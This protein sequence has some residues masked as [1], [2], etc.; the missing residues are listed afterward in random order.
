MNRTQLQLPNSPDLPDPNK[1]RNKADLSETVR[2]IAVATKQLYREKT[3][4]DFRLKTLED[5]T[6]KHW[7]SFLEFYNN[8]KSTVLP[9][10]MKQDGVGDV[11][12]CM[13]TDQSFGIGID[14]SQN[15]LKISPECPLS[16]IYYFAMNSTGQ[17]RV[18][19]G[20]YID[21]FSDD[22]TFAD[23]SAT[24]LVTE[25][26]IGAY[27]ASVT[28]W[29][30]NAINGYLYPRTLTDNVG[31]N[32]NTPASLLELYH[33]TTD[34]ILTITAGHN[35]D[36]DPQIQFRTDAVPTAKWGIR[37]DGTNDNLYIDYLAGGGY[38][39]INTS[40]AKALEIGNGAAGVD[41]YIEVNGETNNLI[42]RAMEDEDYWQFDDDIMMLNQERIYFDSTDTYIGANAD[43]PEDLE[44]AAD[45]DILL[46]PDGDVRVSTDLSVN[47]TI[48]SGRDAVDNQQLMDFP[49]GLELRYREG[50]GPLYGFNIFNTGFDNS[51]FFN[52]IEGTY[53]QCLYFGDGDPGFNIFGISSKEDIDP[54]WTPRFVINQDGNVGIGTNTP[55]SLFEMRLNDA[56]P[57]LTIT[58]GHNTDYDPQIQFRTDAVPTSK[59]GIRVDGTNDNLY[60]DYLAGGGYPI[61]NTSLAKALEI[62]NGA[63][64]VDYYEEWNGETNNG[65]RRWMEDEDYWQFDD[66]IL[67][68]N[69]ERIYFDTTDTYIGANVD[70][71]EDLVIA[72]NQDI[73]LEPDNATITNSGR[74]NNTTRVVTTPYNI[75]ATDEIIVVDTDAVARTTNLPAGVDGTHYSISN[76]GTSGNQV[77]ISPNGAELLLG[78][79]AN[80]LLSDGESLDL[81]YETTEGWVAT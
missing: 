58:A 72:A 64:G 27:V 65:I 1:V 41:Y 49:G 15:V 60:I 50:V 38:P 45:Q 20:V 7:L 62:G 44:I 12:I 10:R 18:G 31:I 34:P 30:R 48:I 8:D 9:I 21:D 66:D 16:D 78:V 46:Q 3:G 32:T 68:Q 23:L 25:R 17:I 11:G 14:N 63:A 24:A 40:Q 69:Q 55:V 79:N 28:Y 67:M 36:Y 39:I 4:I 74:I 57:I 42:L 19:T 71:P 59:W 5:K 29:D 81:Y 26:A 47:G 52:A 77:T 70:D 33:T 22:E 37:V 56:H 73:L 43:D 76:T 13:S 61:I 6:K 54:T 80:F 53:Y 35:T 51:F 75:L 2:K